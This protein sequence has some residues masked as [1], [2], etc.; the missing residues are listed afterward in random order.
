MR[1]VRNRGFESVDIGFD[2][3]EVFEL[4]EGSRSA[5]EEGPKV[6][7]DGPSR[8]VTQ[9]SRRMRVPIRRRRR[10]RLEVAERGFEDVDAAEESSDGGMSLGLGP[11]FL[12]MLKLGIVMGLVGLLEEVRVDG[13]LSLRSLELEELS[14]EGLKKWVR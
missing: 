1:P 8:H 2:K 7:L 4:P 12:L 13:G 10:R 5:N 3:G 6:G 9:R 11:A 14:G